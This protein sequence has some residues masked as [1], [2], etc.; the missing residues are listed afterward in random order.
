MNLMTG[1]KWEMLIFILQ[2]ASILGL[3]SA[4]RP[5]RKADTLDS[6]RH[7]QKAI[8]PDLLTEC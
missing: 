2:T 8:D 3:K 5:A 4:S 1:L 6:E 7:A